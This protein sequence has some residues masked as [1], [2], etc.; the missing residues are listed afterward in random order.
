LIPLLLLTFLVLTAFAIIRLR[1]LFAAV[2]LS[3][4]YSLISAGLFTVMDAV[5][6]AFTEA[7]VGAGISSVLM[8]ATLAFTS[9]REKPTRTGLKVG[10]FLLVMATG[11]LLVYGTLDLPGYGDPEAPVH[12]HMEPRF[13]EKSATEVGP[14]NIVTS[15]LGSYRGYDTLG[16]TAVIFTAAIGVLLLLTERRG[17]KRAAPAV[18]RGQRTETP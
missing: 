16:E 6:V 8:V 15:V 13:L 11:G 3:G 18:D 7:A 1:D 2:M 9:R 10:P 4:I 14:P 12:R 5:D 17:W